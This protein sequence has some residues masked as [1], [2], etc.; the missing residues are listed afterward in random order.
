[1]HDQTKA[2]QLAQEGLALWEKS[3]LAL[4][5]QKTEEAIAL[6][7]PN[8]WEVPVYHSRLAGIYA[9]AGQNDKAR[10][11]YEK[12]LLL[13]LQDGETEG[14]ITIITSRYFLSMHLLEMNLA[15]EALDALQ[16][17]LQAAPTHWLNC[18]AHAHILH[19][20]GRFTEA[21]EAA[22]LAIKY[23]PS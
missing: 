1:M 20:V 10:P 6:A 15:S 11:H 23:A 16:P 2:S 18:I 9:Q 12:A 21:K 5:A 13:H 3:E 8:H 22:Q 7:D 14:G 19:A 17:A 4:A